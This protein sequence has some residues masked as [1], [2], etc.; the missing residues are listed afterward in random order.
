MKIFELV[1]GNEIN[2]MRKCGEHVVI[3]I[4]ISH[5]QKLVFEYTCYAGSKESWIERP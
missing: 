1:L 3:S 5:M 2:E 4:E